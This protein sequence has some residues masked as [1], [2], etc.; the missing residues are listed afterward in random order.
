LAKYPISESNFAK[1][2]ISAAN[3]LMAD[4]TQLKALAAVESGQ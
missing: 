1:S 2:A 3:R 4:L